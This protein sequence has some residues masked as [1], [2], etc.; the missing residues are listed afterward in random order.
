MQAPKNE[1]HQ[2]KVGL[3][4]ASTFDQVLATDMQISWHAD[5]Y[6]IISFKSLC[7]FIIMSNSVMRK[8]S[9]PAFV[10]FLWTSAGL[11]HF[12][13]KFHRCRAASSG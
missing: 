8:F 3:N 4:F 7:N 6:P 9:L 12:A 2:L 1:Q 13:N 10:K 5:T 11:Q